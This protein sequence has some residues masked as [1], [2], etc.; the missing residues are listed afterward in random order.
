MATVRRIYLPLSVR[1]LTAA[2][3]RP[4]ETLPTYIWEAAA[5]PCRDGHGAFG[6]LPLC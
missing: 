3:E 6:D 4:E 2:T 1:K 5:L